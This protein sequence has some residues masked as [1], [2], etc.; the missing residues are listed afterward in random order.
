MALRCGT[1]ESSVAMSRYRYRSVRQPRWALRA[2]VTV[3]L[4]LTAAVAVL[5]DRPASANSIAGVTGSTSCTGYNMMDPFDSSVNYKRSSL[6]SGNSAAVSWVQSYRVAPTDLSAFSTT[7]NSADIIYYDWAQATLCG[8]DW[9]TPSAGGI[10][11]FARCKT[12]IGAVCSQHRVYVTTTWTNSAS[13][14]NLRRLFCH[15]TGHVFGITHNTHSTNSCMRTPSSSGTTGY[16][17][18]EVTDMINFVW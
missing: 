4:L 12:T 3:I 9:W 1:G 16:S 10:V 15:E 5:E 18:H 2:V 13:T 11:G 6:T 17:N 14:W 8:Y 7:S